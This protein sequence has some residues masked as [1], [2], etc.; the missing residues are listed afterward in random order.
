[1]AV[2]VAM[3]PQPMMNISAAMAAVVVATE[4]LRLRV[5]AARAATPVAVAAVAVPAMPGLTAAL[6]ARERTATCA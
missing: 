5:Q 1:V 6:V 2:L 3:A 4:P